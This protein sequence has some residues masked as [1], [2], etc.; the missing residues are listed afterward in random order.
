MN[1]TFFE[2][3]SWQEDFFKKNL[4]KHK[5]T[6]VGSDLI[7]KSVGKAKACSATVFSP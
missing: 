2:L 7:A 3:E 1:I 6:F 4:K 5:L